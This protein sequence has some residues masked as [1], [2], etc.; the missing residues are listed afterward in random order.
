MRLEWRYLIWG[1]WVGDICRHVIRW[2]WNSNTES[3][4]DGVS[5]ITGME[6]NGSRVG[7]EVQS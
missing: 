2:E 4:E 7:P 5:G 1:K 3:V 6:E